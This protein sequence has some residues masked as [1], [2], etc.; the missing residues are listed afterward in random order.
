[1]MRPRRLARII[2]VLAMATS[3]A[4]QT[5]TFSARRES[6]RVDVLVTDNGR[7]VTGLEPADFDVRDNG[8][9]QQVDLVSFQEIP[10]NVVLAL[11]GSSSVSG[12]KLE[13]LNQAGRAVLG[14]L[15]MGDRAALLTF[16]EKVA[17]RER[18]TTEFDQLRARLDDVRP[19]GDTALIDGVQ[20]AMALGGADSGRNLLIVFSD[21]LDTASVL[22][23]ESVLDAAKASETVV[24]GVAIRG[25]GKP[26]FLRDLGA[27]TGGAV[28]E[29][30]STRDLSATFQ[31]ILDEFRQR[32][33][34]SYSP[35]GVAGAGWHRLEVR[36]KGKKGTVKAR[37]GYQAR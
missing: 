34:V 3:L 30:E 13:H 23:A 18:L 20:A 35:Q 27:Q 9:T 12:E 32:Y 22:P 19:S 25:S 26:E 21:G 8:V 1:M 37:A 31:K 29:I 17:V 5:P 4:A 28:F 36:L 10:L 33:L 15:K 24:Y 6:V 7:V 2:V 14:R 16:S 11:D